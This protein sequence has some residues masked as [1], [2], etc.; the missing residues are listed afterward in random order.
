MSSLF[1]CL[2]GNTTNF[3]FFVSYIRKIKEKV[4]SNDTLMYIAKLIHAIELIVVGQQEER[5]SFLPVAFR[6]SEEHF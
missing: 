6:N 1:I 3:F 2:H 5:P 4:L